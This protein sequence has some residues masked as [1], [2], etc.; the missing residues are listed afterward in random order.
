MENKNQEQ[1][2]VKLIR[3]QRGNYG[4]EIKLVGKSEVDIKERIDGLNKEM[5]KSYDKLNTK[6]DK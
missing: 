4:W 3:G 6:E 5:V 2:S 1:N